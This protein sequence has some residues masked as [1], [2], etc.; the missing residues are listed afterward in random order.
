MP[1]CRLQGFLLI[2]TLLVLY[3]ARVMFLPEGALPDYDTVQNWQVAQ[4]IASADFSN[5][6]F[7]RSPL[8]NLF[9]GLVYLFLPSLKAQIMLNA[10]LNVLAVYL[11]CRVVA[12]KPGLTALQFCVLLLVAG[13][14]V[15]MVHTSRYL[16]VESAGLPVFALFL[17]NYVRRCD[18]N[19]IKH[20][21][22]AIF[23]LAAGISINYKFVLLVPVVLAL[24]LFQAS[25]LLNKVTVLKSL[26][27]LASPFVVLGLLGFVLGLR[28]YH[29][30]A[31]YMGVV[32]FNVPNAAMRTGKF[33]SDISFYFRYLFAYESPLAWSSLALY[34][35]VFRPW[36]YLRRQNLQLPDVLAIICVCFLAGMSLLLK[37]PR[38]LVFI[39][40]PLYLLG[41]ICLQ[42]LLQKNVTLFYSLLFFSI[43]F[44]GY[45]CYDAIYKYSE[46]GYEQ[47]AA[48][49]KKE[50]IPEVGQTVGNGLIPFSAQNFTVAPIARPNEWQEFIAKKPAW[51]VADTY[52][53]TTNIQLFDSLQQLPA[54]YSVH[55]PA[56]L[57]PLLF[58]EHAE[59]TG[60]G[61]SKTMELRQQAIESKFQLRL[62]QIE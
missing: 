33:N 20:F 22:W 44:C 25:Q 51:V 34:F 42:R 7:H 38:G 50:E 43:L 36:N 57:S 5:L 41:F 21:Y 6:F 37:A 61:Y 13:L 18:S 12:Q 31:T 32:Q 16:T 46:T 2:A 47:M 45:K 11:L 10:G 27:I 35:I 14:S 52:Y 9:Y 62:L 3:G 28:W 19:Q 59:F 1:F 17:T 24:E 56:L 60:F 58:L 49:I 8:F 55:S 26:A 15:F 40:V 54:R 53:L 30:P 29:Y 39:Y 48:F 23:W 4:Q